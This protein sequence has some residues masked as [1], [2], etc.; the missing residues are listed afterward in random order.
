MIT[1]TNHGLLESFRGGTSTIYY[2][3]K[4]ADL[5]LNE[6]HFLLEFEFFQNCK[7]IQIRTLFYSISDLIEYLKV[8]QTEIGAKC[9]GVYMLSPA[10]FNKSN[11]WQM[12]KLTKILEARIDKKHPLIKIFMIDDGRCISETGANVNLE[13]IIDLKV[14]LTS[15]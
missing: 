9:T 12:D 13:K 4:C 3:F 6:P 2:S 10:W 14:F 5:D 7:P 11:H 8:A 1:T 15:E